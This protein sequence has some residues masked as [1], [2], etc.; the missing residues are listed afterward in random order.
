M[1][2][3]D[4]RKNKCVMKIVGDGQ[5][6]KK[7]RLKFDTLFPVLISGWDPQNQGQTTVWRFGMGATLP[8]DDWA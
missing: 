7:C 2:A 6:Q 5:R 4:A 8:N 1:I 3:E